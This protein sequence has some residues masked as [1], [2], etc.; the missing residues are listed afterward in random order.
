MLVDRER[1]CS[2]RVE[3]YLEQ[4][5]PLDHGCIR[6]DGRLEDVLSVLFWIVPFEEVIGCSE[7]MSQKTLAGHRAVPFTR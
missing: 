4:V 6:F 5:G 1:A 3:Q 7:A 2:F